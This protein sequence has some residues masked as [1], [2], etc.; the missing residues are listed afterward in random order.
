MV[1]KPAWRISHPNHYAKQL[2]SGN[3]QFVRRSFR[4]N[5]Y[6]YSKGQKKNSVQFFSS[7]LS[8]FFSSTL[9]SLIRL[10]VSQSETRICILVL[11]SFASF[12]FVVIIFIILCYFC[13]P[14]LLILWLVIP[15]LPS[16]CVSPHLCFGVLA[17]KIFVG[18]LSFQ[19]ERFPVRLV[20]PSAKQTPFIMLNAKCKRKA[21]IIN[22]NI[23]HT[24]HMKR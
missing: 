11:F 8:S 14:F 5:N 12:Q 4:V 18:N 16:L 17:N 20:K 22:R 21:Q 15:A 19:V 23:R 2:L 10:S 9:R 13:T 7:S 3:V 6:N 1:A 24:K